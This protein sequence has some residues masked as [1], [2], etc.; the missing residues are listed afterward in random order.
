MITTEAPFVAPNS[1]M[2]P[3]FGRTTAFAIGVLVL[4]LAAMS[5]AA[6][7]QPALYERETPSYA[8][9]ALGQDWVDALVAVPWLVV[10]ARAARRGSRRGRLLLGGGLVY[11]AYE[12]VIYAFAVRFNALFLVYCTGLGVSV[13]AL[14]ITAASLLRDDVRSWFRARARVRGPAAFLLAIGVLFAL[15]WLSEILPAVVRGVVPT[16]AADAGLPT[17]PVHVL[18]LS[19][20]LPAHVATGVLLFRERDLG[21]V[22][23]PVLLAFDVLMTLSIAGVGLAMFARGVA[24]TLAIAGVMFALCLASA[25]FMTRLLREMS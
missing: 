10:T 7:L 19:L 2:R 25:S 9:Q 21:Y 24:P 1:E 4:L 11:A 3:G 20:L 6:I 8:A 22:F 23:A 15:L 17:N 5:L 13:L 16:S 18:D 12:F 14:L